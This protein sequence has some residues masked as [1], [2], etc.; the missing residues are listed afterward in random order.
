M[1]E[2]TNETRAREWMKS[3][4]LLEWMPR[5]ERLAALLD[6]RER[7]VREE[8]AGDLDEAEEIMI[9]F[10]LYAVGLEGNLMDVL[11]E[12]GHQYLTVGAIQSAAEWYGKRLEKAIEE[13]SCSQCGEKWVVRQGDSPLCPHGPDCGEDSG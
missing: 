7:E 13:L 5:E 4:G 2:Q 1:T 10:Y 3:E 11:H 6:T 8:C 12:H 9:V